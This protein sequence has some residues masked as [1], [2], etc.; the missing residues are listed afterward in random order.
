MK[1]RLAYISLSVVAIMLLAVDCYRPAFKLINKSDHAVWYE[2]IYDRP[3]N[4]DIDSMLK[5][6]N[7][8]I[9]NL[10][11]SHV[12]PGH[13]MPGDT[14]LIY[15][16]GPQ[17]RWYRDSSVYLNLIVVNVDEF[18]RKDTSKSFDRYTV[19]RFN[20]TQAKGKGDL[21]IYPTEG[22]R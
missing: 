4:I 8:W 16:I 18:A 12:K 14:G 1:Q 22:S 9:I 15:T 13:L 11:T 7:N 17:G 19:Y 6:N 21:I 20:N 10:D 5:A 3:V 2:Y